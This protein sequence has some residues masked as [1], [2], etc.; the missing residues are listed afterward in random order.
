M[1]IMQNNKLIKIL[2]DSAVALG[3]NPMFILPDF[4]NILSNG[5]PDIYN[6]IFIDMHKMLYAKR[7]ILSWLIE[8]PEDE[9]MNKG[10]DLDA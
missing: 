6:K 2:I 3:K 8:K 5:N 4:C 10:G 1:N 9:N 7:S